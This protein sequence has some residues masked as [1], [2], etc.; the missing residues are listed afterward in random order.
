MAGIPTSHD[1]EVFIN[2]LAIHQF[3]TNTALSRAQDNIDLFG[4]PAMAICTIV[5]DI[6]YV[7]TFEIYKNLYLLLCERFPEVFVSPTPVEF[8]LTYID[9]KTGYKETYTGCTIGARGN[10]AGYIRGTT[11]ETPTPT[12]VTLE[13]RAKAMT[14]VEDASLIETGVRNI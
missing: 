6:S 5:G 10:I 12:P 9:H 4:G 8:T 2:D 11:Q 14:K 3:A 1:I 7:G 13:I